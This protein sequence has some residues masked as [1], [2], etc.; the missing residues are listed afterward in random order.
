MIEESRYKESSQYQTVMLDD[1][2]PLWQSTYANTNPIVTYTNIATLSRKI[3]DVSSGKELGV[4]VLGIKEFAIA[5]TYTYMDLGP[6]GFTFIIDS[7]GKVVSDLNKT[8]VTDFAPYP[9]V[10]NLIKDESVASTFAADFAG[11]KVLV[12]HTN[13]QK[14]DWKMISVVPYSYLIKEIQGSGI[15]TLRLPLF[16]LSLPWLLV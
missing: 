16:L 1:S 13:S 7:K 2:G 8:L 6:N 14:N 10:Y 11:E 3:I 12:T 9:F 5:D 15:L 4:L